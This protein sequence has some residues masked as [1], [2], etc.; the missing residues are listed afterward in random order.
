[1][2][3]SSFSRHFVA[4]SGAFEALLKHRTTYKLLIYK[5]FKNDN[6]YRNQ[7][8]DRVDPARRGRR[9]PGAAV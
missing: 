8:Q 1:M 3:C 2:I 5:S 6:K 9:R 4:S 7:L